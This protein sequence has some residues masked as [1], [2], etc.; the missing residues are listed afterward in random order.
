MSFKF[1]S[2]FLLFIIS[3]V[4]V[5][6]SIL[7]LSSVAEKSG[8]VTAK[9]YPALKS[10]VAGVTHDNLILAKNLV[11]NKVFS[12]SVEAPF[13]P[14]VWR[15]PGYPAFVA[16][17]YYFF[18]N[19]Y[20]VLFFQILIIFLTAVL[21]FKMASQLV[22]EKW[23]LALS[24]L[25]ILLPDTILSASALFNEVVFV[26]VF[27]LAIYTFFFYETKSVYLKWILTGFFLALTVYIRPAS[28]YILFFFIP[29]YFCFYLKKQEISRKHFIGALFMVIVFLGTLTPWYIR[30]KR[31]VGVWSF[32]ST[33]PFV[34]FRQNGSQFHAA[35]TGKDILDARNDLLEMAGLPPGSVP[36]DIKYSAV[37]QK[38]ALDVIL[39]H[40]FKYMVFHAT[41]FIPFFTASGIIQYSNLVQNISPNYDAT[42][43]PSLIQALNPFSL[44]LLIT[45]IKNHGWTLIENFFWAFVLLL[46]IV[47]L[48]MSKNVRMTRM[49]FVIIMYFAVVTGPIAH[50]RYRVPVEPLLLI[51]SFSALYLLTQKYK[52]KIELKE[53]KK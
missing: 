14:D 49:F 4:S 33:G 48:W 7:Y 1:R 42:P 44:P 52:D 2:Y 26:F 35:L 34:L 41:T 21:I 36:Q 28:F 31:E 40:P 6:G 32:A 46:T 16:I 22:K 38:V 17:F 18:G 3:L 27:V 25:Y 39:E 8:T 24:V 11:E 37:M 29:G 12:R 53:V 30:N 9:E 47:S 5:S 19:V 43:E 13:E 10:G 23:A 15:T 51:S 50:A 20:S 45:V